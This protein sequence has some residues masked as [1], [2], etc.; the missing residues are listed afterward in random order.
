MVI[1]GESVPWW[2]T[3]HAYLDDVEMLELGGENECSAPTKFPD[4]ISAAA[5]ARRS[6]VS[7]EIFLGWVKLRLS[8][9]ARVI[10]LWLKFT[11]F[12]AKPVLDV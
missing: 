4:S 2:R 5:A 9:V 8:K 10:L 12:T 6:W 7:T 3:D 11:Q 1:G